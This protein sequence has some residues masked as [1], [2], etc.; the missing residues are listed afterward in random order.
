MT[1]QPP[2]MNLSVDEALERILQRVPVLEPVSVPLSQAFGLILAE[3]VRSP[4]DLPGWDNSA[5]DGFAVRSEDFATGE[6][7]LEVVGE[8]YAGRIPD[9]SVAS[10]QALRITTGAPMPIFRSL[11]GRPFASRPAPRCRQAPMP[12]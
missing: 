1:Q 2:N 9:L 11:R 7:L 10:G 12:P 5:V 4:A 6:A 8:A 3:E